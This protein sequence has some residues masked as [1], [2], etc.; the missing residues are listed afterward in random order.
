MNVSRLIQRG[1][2][3]VIL[4]SGFAYPAYAECWKDSKGNEICVPPKCGGNSKCGGNQMPS[5]STLVVPFAAGGTIDS[6]ARKLSQDITKKDLWTLVVENKAGASGIVGIESLK[7]RSDDTPEFVIVSSFLLATE[8]SS[9][10][11]QAAIDKVQTLTPL[12]KSGLVLLAS[13]KSPVTSINDIKIRK[14]TNKS[15]MFYTTKLLGLKT[16]YIPFAGAGPALSTLAAS[17]AETD[18][19]LTTWS[20]GV[21]RLVSNNQLRVIAKS[22]VL[23]HPHLGGIESFSQTSE[24]NDFVDDIYYGIAY[25]RGASHGSISFLKEAVLGFRLRSEDQ[26]NGLVLAVKEDSQ[27]ESHTAKFKNIVNDLIRSAS[28]LKPLD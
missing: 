6:I 1:I 5:N 19:F 12:A 9:K 4:Y 7:H 2:L 28:G 22:K 26:A 8:K 16:Q 27:F 18:F 21:A 10:R 23:S 11:A 20:E 15:F 13:S 25:P 17:A 14:S 24:L 3:V